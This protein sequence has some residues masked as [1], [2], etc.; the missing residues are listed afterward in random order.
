MDI[1]VCVYMCIYVF[2]AACVCVCVYFSRVFI[3]KYHK[4]VGLNNRNFFVHSLK[5]R[6]PTS[7]LSVCFVREEKFHLNPSSFF[8]WFNNQVN[9]TEVN[10]RRHI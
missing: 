7:R 4:L 5:S 8:D 1:Y 2:I 10:R 6:N 3:T 9:I